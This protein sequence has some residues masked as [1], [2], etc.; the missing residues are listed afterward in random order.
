[1]EQVFRLVNRVLSAN[2]RTASLS[3]RTYRVIPL[4]PLAGVIEWIEN[5][6][7][8]GDYLG[9]AHPRFR[10]QDIAPK[11]A[12]G[13][14][15]KEFERAD[16]NPSSKHCVFVEEI[17]ARFKPVFR[18][19][20]LESTY[21]IHQWYGKRLQYIKSAAVGSMIGYI[22]G[23][24]DRHCQNIMIDQNS[25]ELIHIDL[26]MIF[27]FGKTLRI[28]ERVPFRLTRDLVDGMGFAGVEAGFTGKAT[29][30]MIVVRNK[31]DIMLM[32][33]EA[34]K[35]DPLYRWSNLTTAPQVACDTLMDDSGTANK[36]ADRALLR[37]REKLLGLE[38]GT[39]LSERG[40]VSYLVL[41]ATN[42]ELLAQ[43]YHGWQPWM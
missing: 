27:E 21:S 35:Y 37:V 4:Q 8:I 7:P 18:H 10:P 39:L 15:K 33:M 26:N 23:L 19:F 24:G 5:A 31:M 25:G 1:M 2:P 41:S 9:S 30:V 16:S 14:M 28:P 36:E 22:V 3:L 20:F 6:T 13:I 29:S 42:E 17:Q 34:F 43:M 12:R 32:V 38:E 40:Q 11:E